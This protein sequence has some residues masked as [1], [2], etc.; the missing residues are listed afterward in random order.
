MAY[1]RRK[2]PDGEIRFDT[3]NEKLYFSQGGK[4][5][6]VN[7]EEPSSSAAYEH[8]VETLDENAGPDRNI[9]PA[10]IFAAVISAVGFIALNTVL[11][12]MTVRDCKLGVQA[13][14]EELKK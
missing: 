14:C 13:A 3:Q 1:Q 8:W 10:I 6:G 2:L 12:D 5:R 7:A 11:H 4:W 9:W